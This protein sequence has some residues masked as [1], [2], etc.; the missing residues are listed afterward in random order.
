MEV[1]ILLDTVI[2]CA[3]NVVKL[4]ITTK[5]DHHRS[6]AKSSSNFDVQFLYI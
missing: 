3:Q 6:Q 5:E 4:T 1:I 2:G